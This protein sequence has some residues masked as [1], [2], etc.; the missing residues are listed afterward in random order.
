[1]IL[2]CVHNVLCI[3]VIIIT[4]LGTSARAR[5]LTPPLIFFNN[6]IGFKIQQTLVSTGGAAGGSP[7]FRKSMHKCRH[8]STHAINSNLRTVLSE[9]VFY[10]FL[11]YNM[12][13]VSALVY[14]HTYR[15][16]SYY[17]IECYGI[18][19]IGLKELYSKLV[20][21]TLSRYVVLYEYEVHRTIL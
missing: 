16:C 11:L 6:K 10:D 8:M 5:I 19:S 2:S 13:Y 18:L 7:V 21:G 4:V 20:A 14:I 9:W 15:V 12:L 3:F 1:M 17:T